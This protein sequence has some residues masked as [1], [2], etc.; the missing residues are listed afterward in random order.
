MLLTW[1]LRTIVRGNHGSSALPNWLGPRL[2]TLHVWVTH[3]RSRIIAS[4]WRVMGRGYSEALRGL[5]KDWSRRRACSLRSCLAWH[6]ARAWHRCAVG[7]LL[8]RSDHLHVRGDIKTLD[9]AIHYTSSISLFYSGS[10]SITIFLHPHVSH[11]AFQKE[12]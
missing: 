1:S 6:V 9:Y 7:S 5:E 11:R 2:A 4:R 12:L 8:W 10:P 3:P